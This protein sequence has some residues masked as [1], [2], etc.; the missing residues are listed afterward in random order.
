MSITRLHVP[1]VWVERNAHIERARAWH[2]LV[3][4]HRV[5]ILPEQ[6]VRLLPTHIY[7]GVAQ[8]QHIDSVVG[9]TCEIAL[10]VTRNLGVEC[11]G[12]IDFHT[13][14]CRNGKCVVARLGVDIVAVGVELFGRGIEEHLLL[15]GAHHLARVH[16]ELRVN[17]AAHLV[18]ELRCLGVI[19]LCQNWLCHQ[20]SDNRQKNQFLHIV[21]FEN[22]RQRKGFL[23]QSRQPKN[24]YFR[25]NFC[26]A[27][28]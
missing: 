1:R 6:Q 24:N 19:L 20:A 22:V 13:D 12:R 25:E 28:H 4:H 15:A 8:A 16:P 3:S 5:P 2:H 21:L 26:N 7:I 9:G 17:E 27:R 14:T 10:K 18:G 23:N 11:V